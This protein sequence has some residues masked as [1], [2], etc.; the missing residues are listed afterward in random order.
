MTRT[1][2][3]AIY[4]KNRIMPTHFNFPLCRMMLAITAGGKCHRCIERS[5]DRKPSEYYQSF[6]FPCDFFPFTVFFFELNLIHKA[7]VS[8]KT[9]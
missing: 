9:Q 6:P 7:E 4:I 8:R 3:I 5:I 2:I 1:I